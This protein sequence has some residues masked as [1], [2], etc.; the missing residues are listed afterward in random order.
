MRTSRAGDEHAPGGEED[1]GEGGRLLE[2]QVTGQG[3][4]VLD[5]HA[6]EL[7]VAAGIW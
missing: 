7:G 2:G 4:E 3:D 6:H 1:E 5:G